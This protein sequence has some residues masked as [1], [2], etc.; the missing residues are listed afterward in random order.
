MANLSCALV[1]VLCVLAVEAFPNARR[2]RA[3]KA[4][5]LYRMPSRCVEAPQNDI[6]DLGYKIRFMGDHDF[7][8]IVSSAFGFIKSLS[9]DDQCRQHLT[10]LMCRN[11]F[12]KCLPNGR[13]DYGDQHGLI[14]ELAKCDFNLNKKNY[15]TG[16][17]KDPYAS[18]YTFNCTHQPQDPEQKCPKPKYPV[19]IA[20]SNPRCLFLKH[21]GSAG[22]IK[23]G[24]KITADRS[25]IGL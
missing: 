13:I 11:A 25:T 10:K 4:Y 22:C 20:N 23:T 16:I 1:F 24:L 17:H 14:N 18:H 12:P 15:S 21:H 8:D 2:S 7:N 3:E 19:S 5:V 9:M 6:C